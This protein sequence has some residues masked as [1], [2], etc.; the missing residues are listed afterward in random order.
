M[1]SGFWF[2]PRRYGYGVT[3]ID[4][5][6]WLAVAAL[7]AL[8]VGLTVWL[9]VLP[10]FHKTGPSLMQFVAWV[11]LTALFTLS[12][13]AFSKARTDGEWRWRWGEK[14]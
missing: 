14:D 2:K 6:G 1:M 13:V 4:W 11:G 7:A 8:D 10:T 3:P 9:M 12:F 5:R